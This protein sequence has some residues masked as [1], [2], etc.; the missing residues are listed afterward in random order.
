[1]ISSAQRTFKNVA[2]TCP[3]CVT[4][5]QLRQWASCLPGDWCRFPANPHCLGE[6]TKAENMDLSPFW[7]RKGN[8]RI[9]IE[10][11]SGQYPVNGRASHGGGCHDE[12]GRSTS[13]A[14]AIGLLLL[15]PLFVVVAVLIRLTSPGPAIFRQERIGRGF[16]PFHTAS[17]ALWCRMPPSREARSPAAKT[18][19]F[20]A[21]AAFC[22]RPR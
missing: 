18:G 12:A 6:P 20:R 4:A 11:K 2:K 3:P 17:S 7:R 9:F 14:A 19:V 22:E 10:R 1:M 21:S 16:R 13:A 8:S 5:R 15:S